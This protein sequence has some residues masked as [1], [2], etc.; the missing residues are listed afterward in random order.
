MV[1][2]AARGIGKATASILH[3]RGASLALADISKDDLQTFAS[4]LRN[5][6]NQT[7]TYAGV[8]VS[9]TEEVN[10]WTNEV[11]R[12]FGRLDGAANIAGIIGKPSPIVDMKDEDYE[13]VLAVNTGGV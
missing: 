3:S 10:G 9:R 6:K 2:G 1:T 13:K 8:D 12:D 7:V 4:S 11:M 5:S